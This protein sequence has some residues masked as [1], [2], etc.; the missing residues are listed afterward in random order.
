M[1][2]LAIKCIVFKKIQRHFLYVDHLFTNQELKRRS[3]LG[4]FVVADHEY[5]I[6]CRPGSGFKLQTARSWVRRR[7]RRL[8]F[9]SYQN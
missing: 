7:W 1:P 3:S 6:R 9:A 4:I 8:A 5:D 2:K